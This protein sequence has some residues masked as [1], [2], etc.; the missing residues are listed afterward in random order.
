MCGSPVETAF[1]LSF[2]LVC[3]GTPFN[4]APLGRDKRRSGGVLQETTTRLWTFSFLNMQS[5]EP[6]FLHL[7]LFQLWRLTCSCSSL[8][9]N[10]H[11]MHLFLG[12]FISLAFECPVLSAEAQ[13][14]FPNVPYDHCFRWFHLKFLTVETVRVTVSVC[15]PKQ[16]EPSET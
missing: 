10:C 7:P 12:C 15:V 6:L 11:I 1:S 2:S 3:S 13:L 9:L 16:N 5:I 8:F 14:P 4:R